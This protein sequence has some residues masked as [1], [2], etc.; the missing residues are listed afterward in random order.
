MSDAID[1]DALSDEALLDLGAQLE[2]DL[3]NAR[4][5][6][7]KLLEALQGKRLLK[8]GT[9]LVIGGSATVAG[10]IFSPLTFGYSLF[11]MAAGAL[12]V[13]GCRNW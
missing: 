9:K 7:A 1:L 3:A 2:A 8:P 4:V 13:T 12:I 10:V 11:A 5:E 6:E